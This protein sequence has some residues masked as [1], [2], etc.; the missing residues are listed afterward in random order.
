M[1]TGG[2]APPPT[3]RPPGTCCHQ[4][5]RQQTGC[6]RQ[7]LTEA[8]TRCGG[9][10][11]TTAGSSGSTRCS[12][13]PACR[14]RCGTESATG[15]EAR[16][17]STPPSGRSPCRRS[18]RAGQTLAFVKCYAPRHPRRR[19]AGGAIRPRRLPRLRTADPTL[20]SPRTL[21]H[22]C[23]RHLLL[24]EPMPGR[25]WLDLDHASAIDA[26]RR[27]GRAIAVV[28]A[29]PPG[30]RPRSGCGGSAA[31]PR[32]R[33]PCRRAHLPGAARRRGRCTA[34]ADPAGLGTPRADGAGPAAR[35]LPPRQRP[36]RPATA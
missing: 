30:R 1:F 11:R 7:R 20:R 29:S 22:S 27:L 31:R 35:R 13:P 19:A 36:R 12:T 10:S 16:S 15:H 26:L 28:H 8:G 14:L 32:A 24:L 17:W 34:L 3:G 2:R 21:A 5:R 33:H 18:I 9:P 4:T 6:A 25:S 23:D